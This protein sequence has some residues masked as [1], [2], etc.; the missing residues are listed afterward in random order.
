M[1]FN[2]ELI[3][4]NNID[5][6]NIF[7]NENYYKRDDSKIIGMYYNNNFENDDKFN[8][9]I[10]DKIINKILREYN[11]KIEEL[12]INETEDFILISFSTNNNCIININFNKKHKIFTSNIPIN[13]INRNE[14]IHII[15]YLS[16]MNNYYYSKITNLRIKI[17]CIS[18]LLLFQFIYFHM[19]K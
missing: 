17:N 10:K 7:V 2:G 18:S 5:D 3:D 12:N 19:Y 15:D 13:V 8:K 6:F 11:K 1:K 4:I 16:S 14:N 9:I